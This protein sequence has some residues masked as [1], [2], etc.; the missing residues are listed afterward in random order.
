MKIK[1]SS[2]AS[3]GASL[4]LLAYFLGYFPEFPLPDTQP[5]SSQH[6]PAMPPV[7]VNTRFSFTGKVVGVMD[8]DTIQVLQEGKPVK[9]R[10]NG[11][12]APE[13]AAPHGG[14]AKKALSDKAYGKQVSIAWDKED[15]YGRIVGTVFDGEL[16]INAAMVERGMAWAYREYLPKGDY[17]A[18]LVSLERVA[19]DLRLGLWVDDQPI[20]PWEWRR[21]Q[22]GEG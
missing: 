11:I 5:S 15:R 18:Y 3:I 6:N 1:R 7:S 10:L 8:G 14:Q 12:D 9:V 4:C 19:H 21:K 17:R 20:P 2:I 13:K 16:N 22:R